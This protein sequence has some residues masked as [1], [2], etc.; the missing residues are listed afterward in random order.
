MAPPNPHDAAKRNAS[1]DAIACVHARTQSPGH[2]RWYARKRAQYRVQAHRASRPDFLRQIEKSAV[3]APAV[4][5]LQCAFKALAKGTK[6]LWYGLDMAQR[7]E[8]IQPDRRVGQRSPI[9]TT[10][11]HPI[12]GGE[13]DRDGFLYR[14]HVVENLRHDRVRLTMAALLVPYLRRRHGER[15]LVASDCGLYARRPDRFRKP[16]A[17]DIM[18]SLT[19]GD[20]DVPG[21]PPAEDRKSYKLWQEP[22][23]DLI[24]EVVS[25]S[26]VER[27][28]VEKPPQ[29]E[30]LGVR[31]FWLFDP[32][33]DTDA[34]NGLRGWFL[35]DGKY[36]AIPSRIPAP[37]EVPLPPG[38]T[39][40]WSAVLGLYLFGDG[41]DLRL[42]HPRTG[43]MPD[44]A[45][46][47]DAHVVAEAR[48]NR[49]ADRA[50]H[51][52]ARADREAARAAALEAELEALKRS[53]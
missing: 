42:H 21:T 14:L 22:V 33:R 27:D 8:A 50:D 26:S 53:P 45:E 32:H 30:A 2:P 49:E 11:P 28:T 31:E 18:V 25:S 44:L 35:V 4:N 51:E 16:L 39:A 20:I 24:L 10:P 29:Y 48:A 38:T 3:S 47:A 37:H 13:Y 17:P 9:P 19:A 15:A 1:L 5:A 52:A 46:Q 6:E 7:K 36:H 23:P 43:R 34:P 40:C 41:P 12:P